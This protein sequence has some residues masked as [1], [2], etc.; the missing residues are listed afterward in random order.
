VFLFRICVIFLFL[1]RNS[2]NEADGE[3]LTVVF[4]AILSKKFTFD[5]GAVIVIRGDKPVF[6]GG[7]HEGGVPIYVEG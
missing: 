6:A 3:T 5:D 1:F 2:R 4:H 7:W